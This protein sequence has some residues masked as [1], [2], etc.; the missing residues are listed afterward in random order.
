M[1]EVAEYVATLD[2]PAREV[3]GR[4]LDRARA[5]VPEVEEGRSYGLAAYRYRGRPLVTVVAGAR[6]YTVYP[7]SSDVTASVLATLDGYDATKG[8]IRFTDDRPLPD[9]AL[10][11]LVRERRAEIDAALDR[12]RS[13]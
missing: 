8:G 2:G 9:A 5:L 12:P 3:V 4:L 6:G 13:R 11:A 1:G 7:F 10:D